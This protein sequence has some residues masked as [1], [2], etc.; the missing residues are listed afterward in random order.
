MAKLATTLS[1]FLDSG[2][3]N[4][5]ELAWIGE[6]TEEFV[7]R[8]LNNESLPDERVARRFEQT[9]A[10]LGRL[11]QYYSASEVRK[12]MLAPHPQL[13]GER[14]LDQLRIGDTWSINKTIDRLE[15]CGY[16]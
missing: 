1:S 10:I 13:E 16:L 14:A 6:T 2:L 4:R 9:A 5:E 11:D 7:V 15:A 8:W 12:W 3:F